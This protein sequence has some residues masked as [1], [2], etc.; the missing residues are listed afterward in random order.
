MATFFKLHAM[1]AFC[2]QSVVST[3]SQV[4]QGYCFIGNLN[5]PAEEIIQPFLQAD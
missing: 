5:Q 3:P 1:E 2:Y 4:I